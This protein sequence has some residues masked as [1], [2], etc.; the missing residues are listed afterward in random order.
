MPMTLTFI[1]YLLL[2]CGGMLAKSFAPC[3]YPMKSLNVVIGTQSCVGQVSA[4]AVELGRCLFFGID[5]NIYDILV[6]LLSPSTRGPGRYGHPS[7]RKP[8][9]SPLIVCKTPDSFPYIL[10]KVFLAISKRLVE[11]RPPSSSRFSH[12]CTYTC[13]IWTRKVDDQTLHLTW[14][15]A[16]IEGSMYRKQPALG[17]VRWG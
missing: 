4:V 6:S 5:C 17:M 3:L 14:L 9:F 8:R 7:P 10:L 12:A 1:H 15:E 11:A 2:T 13:S 16:E